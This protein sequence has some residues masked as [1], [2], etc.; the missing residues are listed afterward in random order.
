MN[1]VRETFRILIPDGSMSTDNDAA[2]NIRIVAN[3]AG[4]AYMSSTHAT[5]IVA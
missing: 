3:P 2:R 1:T 4:T 5:E